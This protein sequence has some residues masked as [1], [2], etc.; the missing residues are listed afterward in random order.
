VRL[1]IG[2][3]LDIARDIKL[4]HGRERQTDYVAENGRNKPTVLTLQEDHIRA[5]RCLRRQSYWLDE[6]SRLETAKTFVVQLHNS[7][8]T[9]A[10]DEHQLLR[11]GVTVLPAAAF[12][13]ALRM[14]PKSPILARVKFDRHRAYWAAVWAR[15][16]SSKYFLLRVAALLRQTEL[17]GAM[18][19][20]L[21]AKVFLT[22]ETY[23]P[24]VD[25]LQLVAPGLGVTTIG[26]QYSNMAFSVPLMMSTADKFLI[27]SDMYRP[28][29]QTADISPRELLPTGY[30]YDGVANIV[31]ARAQTH[32]ESLSRAGAKFVVCYFDESVQ[33]DRWG[34]IS[35][36][37]HLAELHALA[38]AVI[39]DP[40]FGVVVKSQF[41]FNSPSQLFPEDSIIQQAKATG[42]YLELMEGAHRNDIYPVEAALASNLCI[43]HKFGAT[44]ALE[45]ALSGV[46]TVLLDV[47]GEKTLW[48]A[49]YAQAGIEYKTIGSVLDAIAY[50]RSGESD[51]QSIGDW[52]A[53][54]PHFDPYRDGQAVLRLLNVVEQSLVA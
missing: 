11:D 49:V 23:Y 27:F 25:A 3:L 7:S 16:H 41:M 1:V 44:A 37:D 53:I 26:Y 33:A 20:W 12:S 50:Y 51:Y 17:M 9:D 2:F 4:L 10:A 18:V 22:K 32:R 39:F 13:L 48:D 46:R 36:S 5:D 30:L 6:N 28:I 54:L 42:R 47:Y 35:K 14:M 40:T 45:A 24:F 21:N 15:S 43:G 34:L 8:L 31:R 19:L 38:S 29:Y 52:S